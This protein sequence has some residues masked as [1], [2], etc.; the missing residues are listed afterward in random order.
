MRDAGHGR[1]GAGI[2]ETLY[3]TTT[4]RFNGTRP[5]HNLQ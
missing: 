2:E 4:R 3:M 5:G 1:D